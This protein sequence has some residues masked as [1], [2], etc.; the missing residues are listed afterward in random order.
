MKAIN[1]LVFRNPCISRK[2]S[3]V[4]P[5]TVAPY[6]SLDWFKHNRCIMP[7]RHRGLVRSL[8]ENTS[9]RTSLEWIPS[10]Q[11]SMHAYQSPLL[12]APPTRRIHAFHYLLESINSRLILFFSQRRVSPVYP[13]SI[14]SSLLERRYNSNVS[15]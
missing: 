13:L 15:T 5:I 7:Y 14:P 4:T 11:H 3:Q 10:T 6:G 12:I 2:I 8:T 1:S 9:S